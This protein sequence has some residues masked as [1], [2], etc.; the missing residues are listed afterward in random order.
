VTPPPS[1]STIELSSFVSFD[2]SSLDHAGLQ[3]D[4]LAFFD[5]LRDPLLRYVCSLGIGVREAEDVVQDT[6][7]ALYKHLLA[8][9]DRANLQGWLFRVAHNLALK[10][11][12]RRRID[13]VRL[14]AVDEA[15][16]SRAAGYDPERALISH[17]RHRQVIAVIRALP[18]RERR[19]LH[20]RA[21]GLPYRDIAHVLGISLG[22]VAK[23][24][25]R[26]VGRLGR[27]VGR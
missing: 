25:A 11:R 14:A 20:L 7:V 19:C 22:A 5:E 8:G 23:S 15:A 16:N 3:A 27:V 1:E 21:A 4:V 6:F 26:A 9:K 12:T 18:D 13:A 10:Q 24:V 2:R 17:E